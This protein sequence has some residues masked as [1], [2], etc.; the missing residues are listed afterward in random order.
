MIL[1]SR[2]NYA[3]HV[4]FFHIRRCLWQHKGNTGSRWLGRGLLHKLAGNQLWTR[5]GTSNYT[6]QYIWD[7][8]T[9][10]CPRYLLLALVHNYTTNKL[11]LIQNTEAILPKK[12][13]WAG[14]IVLRLPYLNNGY[15]CAVG[16]SKWAV[17]CLTLVSYHIHILYISVH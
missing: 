17:R 5:A 3:N 8:I 12:S 11:G 16:I 14:K 7:I 10:T 6:P 4:A 9:C 1:L 2:C 13:H 15:S